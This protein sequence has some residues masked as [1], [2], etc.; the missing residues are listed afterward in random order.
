M[1]ENHRQFL[2]LDE[3]ARDSDSESLARLQWF[4]VQTSRLT[5]PRTPIRGWIAKEWSIVR[6]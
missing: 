4:R 6:R 2:S 1:P 3:V 5:S